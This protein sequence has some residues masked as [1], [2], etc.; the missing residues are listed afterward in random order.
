MSPTVKALSFESF[1]WIFETRIQG[2][3]SFSKIQNLGGPAAFD[4]GLALLDPLKI[5]NRSKP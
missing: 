3:Y 4:E 2:S 5:S 1:K